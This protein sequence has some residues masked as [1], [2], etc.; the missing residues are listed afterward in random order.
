MFNKKLN[1]SRA[2]AEPQALCGQVNCLVLFFLDRKIKQFEGEKLADKIKKN[3][4]HE[5]WNIVEL[6]LPIVKD[7]LMIAFKNDTIRIRYF[8]TGAPIIPIEHTFSR[9]EK[10]ENVI[11]KIIAKI[12]K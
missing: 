4:D 11:K 10:S 2:T 6:H 9:E 1:R 3:V 7:P 5:G 12:D 8:E